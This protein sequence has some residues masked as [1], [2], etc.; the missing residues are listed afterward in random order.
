MHHRPRNAVD[1]NIRQ[2]LPTRARQPVRAL[3][4]ARSSAGLRAHGLRQQLFTD[5]LGAASQ[6]RKPSAG[7]AVRSQ[8]PL[9][10]SPGMRA[11][12]ATRSPGSL[13][14]PPQWMGQA[15]WMAHKIL[16]LGPGRQAAVQIWIATTD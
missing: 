7:C 11:V 6:A 2:P 4:D 8:L 15:P 16:W 12:R 1:A 14:S 3:S 5:L 13:L 10:G 9:R